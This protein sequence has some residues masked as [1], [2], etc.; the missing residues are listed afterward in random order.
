MTASASHILTCIVTSHEIWKCLNRLDTRLWDS[1]R[2]ERRLLNKQWFQGAGRARLPITE[3]QQHILEKKM[4]S[5]TICYL[6]TP[7][8]KNEAGKCFWLGTRI[9]CGNWC[10]SDWSVW[11]ASHEVNVCRRH[12][13]RK[14]LLTKWD[15]SA[16]PTLPVEC[17]QQSVVS[18]PA[19]DQM[20]PN[21]LFGSDVAQRVCLARTR[22]CLVPTVK[23]GG[24]M[25][26]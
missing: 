17:W 12:P 1:I 11:R 15:Q 8:L 23:G 2:K 18:E 14:A 25:C 21:N 20:K 19:F 24:G 22:G 6:H 26:C 13:W 3:G 7:A 16:R 4:A 10:F 5:R 9:I